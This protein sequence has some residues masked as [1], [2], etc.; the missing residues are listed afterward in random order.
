MNVGLQCEPVVQGCSRWFVAHN[1]TSQHSHS[2]RKSA[3]N[4]VGTTTTVTQRRDSGVGAS[5]SRSPRQ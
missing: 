1:G 5:L 2:N 4:D 3:G